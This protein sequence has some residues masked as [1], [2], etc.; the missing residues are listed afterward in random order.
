VVNLRARIAR[1]ER[2]FPPQRFNESARHLVMALRAYGEHGMAKFIDELP[3]NRD[4]WE[5]L[6]TEAFGPD[7]RSR[8]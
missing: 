6:A 7:W 5:A 4:G 8:Q 1:L 3:E 2:R